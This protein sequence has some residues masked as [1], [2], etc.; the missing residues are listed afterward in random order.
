MPYLDQFLLYLDQLLLTG[1]ATQFGKD[2]PEYEAAGGTR[3]K[4]QR[5][6]KTPNA[7]A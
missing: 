6:S 7:G 4:P 1:V 2:S 5:P 3:K